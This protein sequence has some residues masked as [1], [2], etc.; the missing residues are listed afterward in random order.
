MYVSNIKR[1]LLL[2]SKVTQCEIIPKTHQD[3]I[4]LGISLLQ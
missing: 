2:E 1:S 3:Q 4:H